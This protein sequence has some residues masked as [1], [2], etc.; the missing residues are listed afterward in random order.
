MKTNK[1]KTKA[2]LIALILITSMAT[3]LIALPDVSAARDFNKKTYA[4]IGSTPNPVGV[5]EET[6]IHL[7]ISDEMQ[8]YAHGYTGLT[9]TV[10]KPDNNTIT[11]GPFRT[12]STGGTG[13]IFT[14]DQ[15]GTYYLQTHFPAQWYNWT[16]YGG[17][18]IWFEASDSEKLALNVTEQPLPNYPFTPLPT[19]Y[20][21]RPI[22]SQHY[23]WWRIAGS[24]VT[25][26]TNL[27]APYNI[28]PETAH[29]LWR[30]PYMMG[31]VSGGDTGLMHFNLG[32]GGQSP[33]TGTTILSGI[34]HYNRYYAGTE[35]NVVAVDLHTGEELWVKNSTN[36]AFGQQL[37]FEAG[38]QYAAFDY[39][40]ET[41]GTNWT[42]SDPLTGRIIYQMTDVPSGT[43]VYGP[44]GEIL[45]YTVSQT[46]GYMSQWNSTAVV[47]AG[48]GGGWSPYGRTYNAT[49]SATGA[50]A[51]SWNVTIPKGLPG[52][53]RT[54]L[55]DDIMLGYYRGGTVLTRVEAGI[56]LDNPPFYAWAISL[57]PE[58]RG[59]L[60]WNRTYQ[61]PPGNLTY[62]FGT[63]SQE[64]RI[65]TM[66][67]KETRKNSAYNLDTGEFMWEQAE[68]QNYLDIFGARRSIMYG[69]VYSYGYA[70]IVYTLDAQTGKLLWSY[71]AK[72]PYNEILWSN[73]WPLKLCFITD[74]K[75]YFTH[76]EHSP[77]SP[78]PRGAPFF[79]LNETTGEEIFRI[80]GA[81]RGAEWGQNPIIGDSIIASW[82][83]YDNQIYGVG[84]GPSS[85]VV[86]VNSNGVNTGDPLVIQ[87]KVTDVSPGLKE[88]G[89]AARFPEGV[90]A[91]ADKDMSEWMKYV[92]LQFD[93]PK[94]V[95]GVAVSITALDP[96]GNYVN[97]GTA[98]S[99]DTGFYSYVWQ[100]PD[101]PGAYKIIASFTGSKSYYPSQA[102]TA[103]IVTSAAATPTP[104]A[105]TVQ[106]TADMY[107][108]PAIVGLFVF[109]AIIGAILALLMLRK[110][111]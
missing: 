34:L 104:I 78:L 6:L 76:G 90:P 86:Q 107:F 49:Q 44:N 94:N 16:L 43:T 109:V 11:L 102:E 26:P 37:K 50:K 28:G 38:N 66:W 12:D 4:Y 81:F 110:R 88:T 83:S 22:D 14:P 23:E 89:I 57:K 17:A 33:W 85:T 5:G 95:E 60:L 24:W 100:A 87:G 73:N 13:Y 31:G 72:D 39:W 58:S 10:T 36:L 51:Y 59:Q 67:C 21:T 77:N 96:N 27:Y 103:T 97:L 106:S 32:G 30:K 45:R 69:K 46:G 3:S 15:V 40:W 64:E 18:N 91:I 7:G 108:V 101:V 98:T 20:W 2:T 82:N 48:L 61:L 70:G 47:A 84:K 92:Y 74:G 63:T 93:K 35:R 68:S 52:S 62:S 53:V 19:E 29:I 79:C 1:N 9:V 65:F 25:T 55:Y 41:S 8:D 111:P 54:I 105:E 99:D 42:A 75:L 80:D 71:T 56:T